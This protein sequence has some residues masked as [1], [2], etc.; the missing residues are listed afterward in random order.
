MAKVRAIYK[1][2]NEEEKTKLKNTS[3]LL[4]ISV[5]QVSHEDEHFIST[6]ELIKNTFSSCTITLHDSLQ[7]FTMAI[8]QPQDAE[9]FHSR[10]TKLGDLWLKRNE[11]YYKNLPYEVK[12]IRWDDYFSD[13][14]FERYK[15][16][17]IATLN[18]DIE[19][20]LLFEASINEYL[21]RYLKRLE[22]PENFDYQKAQQL[23]F[24]YLV[25]EC[26]V[27]CLWPKTGCQFELYAG[28]HN[29]AMNET[30]KRFIE[31]YSP[32]F[33]KSIQIG[34]H[35]SHMKPQNLQ[36]EEQQEAAVC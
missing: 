16:Q 11:K 3:C 12:I 31:P 13:T 23:C 10:A 32:D 7:R 28:Q 1:G 15:N 24:E 22:K 18:E 36:L 25:E 2:I 35:R 14:D 6:M 5:G 29:N 27:L 9:Y 17:I 20:K 30:R 21:T 19:Y 26:A 4:T 33:V 8:N 34:F